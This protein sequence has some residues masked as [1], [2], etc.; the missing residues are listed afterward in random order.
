MEVRVIV[1]DKIGFVYLQLMLFLLRFRLCSRVGRQPHCWKRAANRGKI[2]ELCLERRFPNSSNIFFYETDDNSL[3]AEKNQLI[4]VQPR[5][6]NSIYLIKIWEEKTAEFL[7]DKNSFSHYFS[8]TSWR[9][10]TKK[11]SQ[12]NM[13][14]VSRS[15]RR[16][17]SRFT[18]QNKRPMT[19][20]VRFYTVFAYFISKFFGQFPIIFFFLHNL[21]IFRSS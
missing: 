4:N 15:W 8:L 13:Q 18:I 3:T 20:M 17:I 7:A 14:I 10:K 12:H 19:T 21:S 6:V 9:R 5:F 11:K 16:D 2:H 1:F